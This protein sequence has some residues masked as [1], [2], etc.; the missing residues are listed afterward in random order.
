MSI[1]DLPPGMVLIL[2][3]MVAVFLPHNLRR[4][5]LVGAPVFGFL[6]LI[7]FPPVA[8]SAS[9]F[10]M[11]L[12]TVR[13]DDLS[14]VWGYIFYIAAFISGIYHMHVKDRMQDVA[15]LSYMGSAIGVVFAGD[16]VTLFVYWELTAVTSVFLIFANRTEE[17]F[18]A[19]MR[20]LLVQIASGVLLLGGIVMFWQEKGSVAF[21]AME[22]DGLATWLILLGFGVKAAFPLLHT[23]LPDA[24]PQGTVSGTVIL[25]SFTTKMA[26]YTLVRG[27]PGT[28][29]LIWIGVVM[30]LF[31]L[32]FAMAENDLRR[33]LAYSLNTQLGFMVVAVGIGSDLA[34]NGVA[35]HAFA[36]I[37]YKSLLFMAVGS[38]LYRTGTAKV[39][40]LGGQWPNMKLT[41]ILCMI[42]ALSMSAPLFASFVS[43]SLILS[44]VAKDDQ[45]LVWILLLLAAAAVFINSGLKVPYTI[46]FAKPRDG[47][48]REA[49]RE[50]ANMTLAM[51]IG[52]LLCIGVGSPRGYQY[53]YDILPNQMEYAPYTFGHVITQLQLLLFAALGF[54]WL[55]RSGRYPFESGAAI[56]DADWIVRVPVMRG[57]LAINGFIGAAGR[58]IRSGLV[59]CVHAVIDLA[60]R[61]VGSDGVAARHV[62]VGTGV[63]WL[64]VMLLGYLLVYLF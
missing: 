35:A 30:A 19:G 11:E 49:K 64:M 23:W 63:L 47:Q 37:L 57:V 25:S 38:V 46:F 14:L 61:I 16:L 55:V 6:Q 26:I 44:S 52:A 60:D 27:F 21:T 18:Q 10:G 29:I 1:I 45:L 5:V 32:V 31:P 56:R 40:E 39:S 12:T 33:T 7:D 2:A 15:A 54:F 36:H 34:I 22:L 17:S 13:V 24:Y 59:E 58:L 53:L 9:F 51:I 3:A 4:I 50:P 28:E 48:P 62:M 41:A 43:K 8:L 20:Y 42:G